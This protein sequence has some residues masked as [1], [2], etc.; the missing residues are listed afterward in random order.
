M[1]IVLFRDAT[2]YDYILK[3]LELI[4]KSNNELEQKELQEQQLE[5][6]I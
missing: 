5:V 2:R 3:S 4:N 1:K 6:I